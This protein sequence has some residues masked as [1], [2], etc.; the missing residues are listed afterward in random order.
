[1]CVCVCVCVYSSY[2]SY[3]RYTFSPHSHTSSEYYPTFTTHSLVCVI[4]YVLLIHVRLPHFFVL[5]THVRLPHFFAFFIIIL[6]AFTR[7]IHFGYA[8]SWLRQGWRYQTQSR[9]YRVFFPEQNLKM[10][11]ELN[12]EVE[13]EMG[14]SWCYIELLRSDPFSLLWGSRHWS[15]FAL[16][17]CFYIRTTDC[18]S[19]YEATK[20]YVMKQRGEDWDWE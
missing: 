17:S 19:A 11:F 8:A 18:V 7:R 14:F 3:V 13:K 1:M 5:L 9:A 6:K 20:S 2:A 10:R 16:L 12:N 15:I 4:T